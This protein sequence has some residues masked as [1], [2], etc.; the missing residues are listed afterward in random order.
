[1]CL[2]PPPP[3]KKK[4][5]NGI[6]Y[7]ENLQ[8]QRSAGG[9][10]FV[11]WGPWTCPIGAMGCFA[12]KR[13]EGHWL[14]CCLCMPHKRG[15]GS[16]VPLPC[17][18]CCP[19][20]RHSSFGSKVWRNNIHCHQVDV[21]RRLPLKGPY[22]NDSLKNNKK[23]KLFSLDCWYNNLSCIEVTFACVYIFVGL[24]SIF[25]MLVP[26]TVKN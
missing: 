17:H 13:L 10:S 21:F 5:D 18:Q 7:Q 9:R 3:R 20:W 4:D 1:M 19:P 6:L 15:N 24:S 26:P 23:K 14:L 8:R 25:I 22:V 11:P 16:S 12:R 2:R